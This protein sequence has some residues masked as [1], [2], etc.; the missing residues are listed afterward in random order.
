MRIPVKAVTQIVLCWYFQIRPHRCQCFFTF[1]S[2]LSLSLLLLHPQPNAWNKSCPFTFW[3]GLHYTGDFCPQS[4]NYFKEGYIWP[5]NC[6]QVFI[7]AEMALFH[8]EVGIT[9]N[10]FVFNN[11]FFLCPLVETLKSKLAHILGGDFL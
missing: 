11:R 4:G 2:V 10:S 9:L 3:K 5:F 8:F 1:V 7:V 6:K